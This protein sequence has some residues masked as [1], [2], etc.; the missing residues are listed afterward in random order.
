MAGGHALA[1]EPDGRVVLVEG[2]LPG[3]L[4]RVHVTE[5]RREVAF[6]HTVEVVDG[7]PGRVEPPCPHVAEGCGGCDLQ[8]AQPALQPTLKLDIVRDALRRLGR[9][10]DPPVRA[11]AVLRGE[12][13]RTTVRALVGAE[14]RAGLRRRRS[15]DAVLLE[16]C[17]VAHPLVEE[18]L[19]DGRFPGASEVTVRAGDATGERL[20]VVHQPPRR[21]RTGPRI[22]RGEL[23]GGVEVPD[24]VAVAGPDGRSTQG[25][26]VAL[27]E[28]VAGRRWRVSARSFFQSRPDGA[29]ALADEVVRQ[30]D[31]ACH[32]GA[33]RNGLLVD[34][35]AGVGLLAGAVR[36]GGWSGPVVAVERS[37]SSSRDAEANLADL[38]VE[39]VR[40][41]VEDWAPVPASVVVADPAREGLGREVV[42]RLAATGAAAIVLVSCDAA[43]LGRDTALLAA[44]GYAIEEAVLV[45]LFVH[46]HHVEVVSRFSRSEL[47]RGG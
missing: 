6:A 31:D 46:T 42:E 20:V 21:T 30:V 13:F 33:D 35:Y 1:R 22:G 9:V 3:E 43:S 5:R 28:E 44:A 36:S 26:P 16:S 41:A 2:A 12:D 39:V 25:R 8:H 17:L 19:V 38:D 11:G 45:D 27:H 40:G 18:V 10:D 24:D 47:V 34:A 29:Q 4:V 23:L 32:D 37:T 15:H 7:V 14:G